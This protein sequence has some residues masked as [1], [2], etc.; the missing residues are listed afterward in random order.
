MSIIQEKAKISI[1]RDES[2]PIGDTVVNA[3]AS[4]N[5]QYCA[6]AFKGSLGAGAAQIVAPSVG[7]RIAG[8]I[9]DVEGIAPGVNAANPTGIPVGVC[10]LGVVPARLTAAA[11][12]AGDELAVGD[13]HGRLATATGTNYVVGIA[14]QGSSG[15]L[16]TIIPVA[17]Y[18]QYVL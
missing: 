8:I 2:Y 16:D 13:T 12:N 1:L 6:V 3:N 9:K 18:G 15:S 17:M 11:V 4:D 14:Q 10:V 7:G 5:W